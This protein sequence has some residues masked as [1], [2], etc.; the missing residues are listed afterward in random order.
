MVMYAG[1]LKLAEY[2]ASARTNN[3]GIRCTCGETATLP[4]S[5]SNPASDSTSTCTATFVA[6]DTTGPEVRSTI[7][8]LSL[9]F[10]CAIRDECLCERSRV[11]LDVITTK[12]QTQQS[13]TKALVTHGTQLPDVVT[14]KT[15]R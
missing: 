10:S 4:P 14:V 15:V 6:A 7:F 12:A 9:P 2:A 8:V 3:C 1:T 13:A 11:Q 5:C